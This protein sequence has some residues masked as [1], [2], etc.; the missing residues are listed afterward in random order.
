MEADIVRVPVALNGEPWVETDRLIARRLRRS[1]EAWVRGLGALADKLENRV[2]FDFVYGEPLLFPG[3]FDLVWDLRVPYTVRT[4]LPW[5]GFADFR[6]NPLLG[7][8][9]LGFE[10]LYVNPDVARVLWGVGAMEFIR[11]VCQLERKGFPVSLVVTSEDELERVEPLLQRFRPGLR[12]ELGVKVD[13]FGFV[14]ESFEHDRNAE[15]TICSTPHW[16]I[17]PDGHWFPCLAWALS[18]SRHVRGI[19][20][21]DSLPEVPEKIACTVRRCVYNG[22]VVDNQDWEKA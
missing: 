1:L 20:N 19:G 17:G 22:R 7:D 8:A 18:T 9:C 3:F 13:P 15:D 12:H 2:C 6:A 21:F 10:C 11:R 14:F 5:S 16:L 4:M